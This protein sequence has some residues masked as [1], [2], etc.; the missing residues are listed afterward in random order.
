METKMLIGS[1][2]ETGTETEEAVLNPKTEEII[3]N[4]PEASKDQVDRAV[5]AAERAFRSWSKNNASRPGR[6]SPE[7]RRCNRST[8]RLLRPA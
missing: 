4:L 1:D 3:L 8:G 5:S 6:L 7:N 2:F